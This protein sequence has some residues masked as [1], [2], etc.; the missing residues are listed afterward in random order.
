MKFEIDFPRNNCKIIESM[1]HFVWFCMVSDSFGG[2][3]SFEAKIIIV[4]KS[5]KN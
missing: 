3:A 2:F 4:R 1:N 5:L